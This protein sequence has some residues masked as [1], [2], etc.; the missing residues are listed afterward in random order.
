MGNCNVVKY[1]DINEQDEKRSLQRSYEIMK[2][3][4]EKKG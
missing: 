2:K 4:H 1:T 3:T